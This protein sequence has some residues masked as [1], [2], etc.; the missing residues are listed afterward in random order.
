MGVK[1][2]VLR[3]TLPFVVDMVVDVITDMITP[4][5]VTEF[6]NKVLSMIEEL[7]QKTETDLDDKVLRYFADEMFSEENYESFGKKWVGMAKEYVTHSETKYDDWVLPILEAVEA[8]F[9]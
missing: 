6:R 4:E 3:A 5:G 1:E 8:A 9:D 2:T 7:V